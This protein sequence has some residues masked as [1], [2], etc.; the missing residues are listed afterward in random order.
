MGLYLEG[1]KLISLWAL[2]FK[3]KLGDGEGAREIE[4]G[5]GERQRRRWRT[6]TF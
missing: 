5:M 1:G 3:R 2:N 4:R 6:V